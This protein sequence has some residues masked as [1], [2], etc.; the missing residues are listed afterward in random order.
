M[1][2]PD[3]VLMACWSKP[4]RRR[5]QYWWSIAVSSV[6]GMSSLGFDFRLLLAGFGSRGGT[7]L[8]LTFK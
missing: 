2:Q 1:V 3:L 6:Y 7:L 4:R 8:L 5:S